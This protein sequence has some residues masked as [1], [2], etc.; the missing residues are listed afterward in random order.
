MTGA[1]IVRRSD[2]AAEVLTVYG[3]FDGA[4]A[5]ALRVQMDES[6][7]DAFVIDLTHAEEACE[8]A[9]CVLAGWVREHRREK[10]VRFR[11]GTR[12]QARLLS[13]FGLDLEESGPTVV[14]PDGDGAPGLDGFPLGLRS[15]EGTGVPA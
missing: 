1:A 3:A 8:F 9:A 15:P 13:A 14:E 11:A 7:A 4:S 6:A 10:R 2:G 5:W 12:E